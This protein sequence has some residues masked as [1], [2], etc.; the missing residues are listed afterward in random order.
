M[1]FGRPFDGLRVPSSVEGLRT[2]SAVEGQG[3]NTHPPDGYPGRGT[4]RRWVQAYWAVRRSPS[5]L[6][7]AVSLSNGEHPAFG[8]VPGAIQRRRVPTRRVGGPFSAACYN[9]SYFC[10]VSM[11]ALRAWSVNWKQRALRRASASGVASRVRSP[12]SSW[13]T[14]VPKAARNRLTNSRATS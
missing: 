3:G 2:P 5:T 13:H 12:T 8:W 1:S 10:S 4:H 14:V 9:F 7:G 11:H 6:L